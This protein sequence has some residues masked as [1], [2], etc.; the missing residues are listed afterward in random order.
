MW[1]HWS[2]S[3]RPQLAGLVARPLALVL[4]PVALLAACSDPPTSSPAAA[5][6][7]SRDVSPTVPYTGTVRA[8][9]LGALPGD[10]AGEA[11]FVSEGGVVYGRSFR[12]V[13]GASR[14]FRWTQAG[15]MVQVAS[16]P[17]A[18]TYPLPTV[19]GPL[20][21]R[22]LRAFVHAANA[23]GEA[24]GELCWFDCGSAGTP[25][26]DQNSRR[27]FRYSSGAR[28]VL[29]DTRGSTSEGDF[30]VA[31]TSHGLSINR[32]G[33]IG[34][35]YWQPNVSVD[36]QSFFWSP[37]DS[38]QLVSAP[39][40]HVAD[41]NDID[42]VLNQTTI[43][44]YVPCSSVWRADLGLRDLVASSGVCQDADESVRALAQ[45]V[46]GPLV[47]GRALGHAALWRVPAPNRAAYPK[48]D[49]NPIAST[50]TI[51]LART[52]G[53]YHQFIRATQSAAVGPY[54]ELVD[55]GDGTS[56]R[57]T[58]STIAGKTTFQDHR[59]TRAGTYWVRVYVKDARGRWGVD[60]RRVTVTN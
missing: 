16:I 10:V 46:G 29:L 21:P 15:G 14:F 54:L 5:A 35:V 8:V 33:H 41:V 32:W 12:T 25:G 55:W 58:R 44:A 52:G 1:R 34:G 57:R 36:P 4:L 50:A 19:T 39:E 51:S 18:P 9:D 28:V 40:G 48:V 47:V 31:G 49:A 7:A 24:T 37:V 43:P 6:G 30:L 53:L 26:F 42:Q 2:C 20:P 60:E 17:T 59:Y 27:L 45:Q 23:K 13:G 11:T 56:S 38:V 3:Y 22:F